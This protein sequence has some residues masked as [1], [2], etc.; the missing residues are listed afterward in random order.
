MCSRTPASESVFGTAVDSLILKAIY[1]AEATSYCH[2][3]ADER[4]HIDDM[5]KEG[6]L[7]RRA[8]LLS[9]VD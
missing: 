1:D 3:S 8:S 6:W 5:V 9:C 7:V 4:A 2:Y